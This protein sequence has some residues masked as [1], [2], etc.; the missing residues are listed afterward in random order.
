MPTT[1]VGIYEIILE[2]EYFTSQIR[3]VFHYLSTTDQDDQQ[4]LCAQAFD[5]DMLQSIADL[6]NTN[7][8]Y[9]LIRCKNLSGNLADAIVDPSVA[10]GIQV[11]A[12]VADFVAVSFLYAR[13]TK[14]TRNGFKRFSALI[15][16][17][18]LGGGFTVPFLG[19]MNA[20]ADIFETNIS[21]VGGIFQPI[22]LRKPADG[23]GVFT[24]NTLNAV[25]ALNRVTTQNSRKTF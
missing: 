11:G 22:I 3:N 19:T 24:F 17:N 5:E 9:D 12:I 16:E 7:L 18:V 6:A 8:V 10:N 25:Q 21:T 2:Q 23:M 15:E 4:D 20:S 1:N 14:D 13:Q